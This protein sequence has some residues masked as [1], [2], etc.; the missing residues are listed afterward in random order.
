MRG[1][2][3]VNQKICIEFSMH[4]TA[5]ADSVGDKKVVQ[6]SAH[7]KLVLVSLE[8]RYTCAS[9]KDGTRQHLHLAVCLVDIK[10]VIQTNRLHSGLITTL[11]PWGVSV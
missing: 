1:S 2:Q 4:P 7:G 9:R 8:A 11:S 10:C 5:C 3:L 6:A